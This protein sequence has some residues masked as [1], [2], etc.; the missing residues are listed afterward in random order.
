MRRSSQRLLVALALSGASSALASH[1]SAQSDDYWI[2]LDEEDS[3]GA[4]ERP[5]S[6]GTISL[7]AGPSSGDGRNA[8]R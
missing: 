8:S 4:G 2:D 1:A 6:E 5:R 7:R 3:G